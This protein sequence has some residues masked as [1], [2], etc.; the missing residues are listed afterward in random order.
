MPFELE[1]DLRLFPVISALEKESN[2]YALLEQV[3]K[4]ERRKFSNW[5]YDGKGCH[6]SEGRIE[7][8]SGIAVP[9]TLKFGTAEGLLLHPVAQ[10]PRFFPLK[11]KRGDGAWIL[12]VGS[13]LS[14]LAIF[15]AATQIV[16]HAAYRGFPDPRTLTASYIRQQRRGGVAPQRQ[17]EPGRSW[18]DHFVKNPGF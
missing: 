8:G 7:I 16:A 4:G 12:E 5:A 1:P 18:A 15:H 13:D 9:M 3:R 17:K 14:E 11:L 2:A 6:V 10:T